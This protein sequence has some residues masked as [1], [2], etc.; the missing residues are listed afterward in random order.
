MYE[1]QLWMDPDIYPFLVRWGLA[2]GYEVKTNEAYTLL[3]DLS[4][5]DPIRGRELQAEGKET[6]L[7]R[8]E[9][10]ELVKSF[11]QTT[12][13]DYNPHYS[14]PVRLDEEM[15]DHHFMPYMRKVVEGYTVNAAHEGIFWNVVNVFTCEE[16]SS[17]TPRSHVP[18]LTVAAVTMCR[19]EVAAVVRDLEYQRR[20]V[21][22]MVKY[23]RGSTVKIWQKGIESFEE[24]EAV[25][26]REKPR[27]VAGADW[28]IYGDMT[29]LLRHLDFGEEDLPDDLVTTEGWLWLRMWYPGE[30]GGDYWSQGF[31]D[32]LTELR[33]EM[34]QEEAEH[35]HAVTGIYACLHQDAPPEEEEAPAPKWRLIAGSS[36]RPEDTEAELAGGIAVIW[37]KGEE[38]IKIL[39]TAD[40]EDVDAADLA[41]INEAI[42]SD[43][44]W[45]RKVDHA[46]LFP[47]YKALKVDG[48]VEQER[49][50][51]GEE[52]QYQAKG[53]KQR[54]HSKRGDSSEAEA[55][56]S[57]E[58]DC[59]E[60]GWGPLRLSRDRRERQKPGI[61]TP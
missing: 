4:N 8:E 16:L 3:Y 15:H 17:T 54:S 1:P 40:P 51:D 34:I 44:L 23:Q 46:M 14:P 52:A 50:S 38:G 19:S 59:E 35:I 11:S 13:A 56:D 60:A 24:A 32:N 33:R 48:G 45:V 57:F 31:Y 26:K 43:V 10:V 9:A 25:L 18:A 53:A 36:A 37:T 49:Y 29:A 42:K 20:M 21:P 27:H 28:R 55:C 47:F 39:A 30:Y 6:R 12:L 2:T 58:Q 22:Y 7:N 61:P 5:L 41:A